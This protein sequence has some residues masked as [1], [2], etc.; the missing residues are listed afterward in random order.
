MEEGGVA[1]FLLAKNFLADEL[2]L[3]RLAISCLKY[4]Y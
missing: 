1:E 2:I 4:P 3:T